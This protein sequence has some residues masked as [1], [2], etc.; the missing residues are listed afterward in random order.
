MRNAG[1]ALVAIVSLTTVAL[2]QPAAAP[3]AAPAQSWAEKMFKDG[4]TRD[5]GSVPKGGVLLHRFPITNI[6]AVKLDITNLHSSCGCGTVTASSRS[7]EPRETGYIEV[8][9]DTRRFSGPKTI[10][11]NV[12]VGPQFTSTAELKVIAN[13]RT[14]VVLNPGQVMFGVVSPGVSATQT[15]DVEY[16]GTLDWRALEIIANNAPFTCAFKE[17]YRRQG[18]VGYQVS[19]LLKPDLPPGEFRHEI[20]LKTNDP[21][22]PL[23]PILVQGTVGAPLSVT[24]GTLTLGTVH[25]GEILT[26]RV[27]V[28]GAKPFRITSV[29]G[30]GEGILV[31]SAKVPA[32]VQ[33]LTLTCQFMKPG[34]VKRTLQIKTDMDKDSAVSVTVEG[35]VAQ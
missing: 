5:F 21:D 4:V 23:V 30:L 8:A 32:P 11:I 22:T 28:R 20:Q 7:L 12:T 9:M 33:T 6:Y 26:K 35:T 16:A 18:Q 2:A 27:Q 3:S 24:P 31:D 19:V 17:A 10:K 1:L 25:A 15:I 34:E 29:D 14:D 13:S